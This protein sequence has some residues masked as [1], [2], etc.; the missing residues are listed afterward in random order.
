[1]V[2][3]SFIFVLIVGIVCAFCGQDFVSLGRHAWRCKQRVHRQDEQSQHQNN[4]QETFQNSSTNPAVT[5]ENKKSV[6]CCCGK[7]CKG[8][9]GLK[10]HQRSCRI[11]SGLNDELRADLLQNT[12]QQSVN[13]EDQDVPII[14]F[15][16]DIYPGMKAGINLSKTD[17]QWS[18]ANDYF[19]TVLHF[20]SPI[21]FEDLNLR[22]KLLND[23]VYNYFLNEFGHVK[24]AVSEEL[25]SK[26]KD[27]TK[28]ELKTTL[29][30]LKRIKGGNK[31]RVT[32]ITSKA[33]KE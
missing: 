25:V 24:K 1:M 7:V 5:D 10:M 9:R 16:E 31:I 13:D 19:K 2:N 3:S 30:I 15:D 8:N 6:T 20:D 32:L 33:S 28:K 21:R 4:G 22:I 26:Y 14:Y 17:E 18:T 29:K 11:I 23:T 12:A 27:K